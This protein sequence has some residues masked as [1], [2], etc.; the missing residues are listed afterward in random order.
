[1]TELF[2]LGAREAARRIAAGTLTAQALVEACLERIAAREA[3]IGAWAWLDPAQALAEARARDQSPVRGP[4]HGVPIGV[5]DNMDTADMPTAYGSRCYRGFRPAADAAGVALARAAGAVVLGKTESTEFAAMSPARTRHPDNPAHTPGGSSSGSAAGVADGMMPL[6][7]GSQTAGS[8]IRPASFCG[9][10]GF[11]PSFGLVAIAGTKALAPNLD[12]VG[13]FARS[14][15]D[16]A[17]F[18]A[19]LTGRPD[20]AAPEAVRRPRLGLFRTQP[21][22]QAQPATVAAL[23]AARERLG[24]AGADVRERAAYPAFDGLVPTA[25]TIMGHEAARSLAWERLNRSSE[26]MPLTAGLLEE[27][28]AITAQAYD[29]ARRFAA[30][31]RA[32]I[33]AF[34]ADFDALLVPAAPGEAPPIASTGDPVFNRAW[35]LLHLPCITLPAGRGPTGL[36]VGIQLIGRPGE[37]AH[38][39]AVARFAE[40]ALSDASRQ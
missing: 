18:I 2:R 38:L 28:L 20:L 12:T 36:P 7:F 8:I 33:T 26:I 19:A 34:F 9:V 11:K 31:S 13:G 25:K 29:E 23:D 37:D 4:L 22:D 32:E 39:L 1:M 10:V 40:A 14:V 3:A 17:W 15:D 30:A 5:K 24:R 27:G 16:I 35:T 6:A 21:W